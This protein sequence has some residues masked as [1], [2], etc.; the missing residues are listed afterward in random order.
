MKRV[1]AAAIAAVMML[2]LVGCGNAQSVAESQS[3][4]ESQSAVEA[5]LPA[6]NVRDEIEMT[7]PAEADAE[8]V[9]AQLDVEAEDEILKDISYE[10]SDVEVATVDENGVVTAVGAGEC[11]I[12]TK[13]GDETAETKVT[14]KAAEKVEEDEATAPAGDKKQNTSSKDTAGKTTGKDT[15]KNGSTDNGSAAGN[16]NASKP[17]EQPKQ[18]DPTPAPP[19]PTPAPTPVPAPPAPAPQE[20]T[21]REEKLESGEWIDMSGNIVTDP[22]GHRRVDT[23]ENGGDAVGAPETEDYL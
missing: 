12:T 3:K 4:V 19:A 2:S 1:V 14:V 22:D 9:I 5:P 23:G 8:P 7:L 20:K 10:S 16:G 18:P 15:S 17:V 21:E 11:V 6:I 13:S